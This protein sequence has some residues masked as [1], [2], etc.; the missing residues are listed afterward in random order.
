MNGLRRQPGWMTL[1][2]RCT[3]GFVGIGLVGIWPAEGAPV[4]QNALPQ[5]EIRNL[6]AWSRY[7][8]AGPQVWS[9]IHAPAFTPTVRNAIWQLLR[10]DN[11][12]G[13]PQAQVLTNPMIDYLLWRRSVNPVRFDQ[14]HPNLGPTLSQLLTA[15]PTSAP[16]PIYTPS[17][18]TIPLPGPTETPAPIPSTPAEQGSTPPPAPIP[19]PSTVILGAGM[20]G[21][22]LWWRRRMIRANAPQ[23]SDPAGW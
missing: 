10:T 13:Q 16:T 8:A 3:L 2:R 21:W 23:N 20:I 19:E 12:Q 22:G 17:P 9:T 14:N 15:P 11:T 6:R 4:R 18:Q 7:L 1:V 5:S